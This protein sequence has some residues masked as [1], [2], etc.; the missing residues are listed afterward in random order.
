MVFIGFIQTFQIF[1]WYSESELTVSNYEFEVFMSTLSFYS[2]HT[3][4]KNSI[5]IFQK[6]EFN[7]QLRIPPK[8]LKSL[9]K[10][11]KNHILFDYISMKL[12]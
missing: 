6:F 8:Y 11:D 4:Y 7:L 2:E 5:E 10:T 1:W 12:F 3:V 9:D